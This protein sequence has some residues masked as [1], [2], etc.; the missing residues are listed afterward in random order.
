MIEPIIALAIVTSGVSQTIPP[1]DPPV[2]SLQELVIPSGPLPWSLPTLPTINNHFGITVPDDTLNDVEHSEGFADDQA[3]MEANWTDIQDDIT[4]STDLALDWVGGDEL[5]DMSEGDFDTGLDPL[6]TGSLDASE[7]GTELGTQVA[8]VFQYMRFIRDI[9]L[10]PISAAVAMMLIGISWMFLINL[11][12]FVV[13][14]SG[15][16][17]NL[18]MKLIELIPVVE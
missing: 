1:P 18:A 2:D 15:T 6:G 5:P 7:F 8:V 14:I 3:D 9:D 16:I 4:D 12:K 11:I 10:G 17:V 13:Q